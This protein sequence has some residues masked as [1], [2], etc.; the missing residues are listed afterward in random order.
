M[1]KYEE[2]NALERIV[3]KYVKHFQDDYYK[4][5]LDELSSRERSDAYLWIVRTNGTNLIKKDDVA[6]SDVARY[7]LEN[8]YSIGQDIRFYEIDTETMHPHS[9]RDIDNY[10]ERCVSEHKYNEMYN[11]ELNELDYEY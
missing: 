11:F 3:Q 8:R 10:Y 9:I 7:Y 6:T 5:D 1:A 4:Y 2:F